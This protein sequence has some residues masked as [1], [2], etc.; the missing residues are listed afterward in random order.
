MFGVW[1]YKMMYMERIID[2]WVE[3]VGILDGL[4]WFC[5]IRMVYLIV[6][7]DCLKKKFNKIICFWVCIIII[8]M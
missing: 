4:Y 8:L 2:R 5:F 3:N 1:I 6:G 7:W